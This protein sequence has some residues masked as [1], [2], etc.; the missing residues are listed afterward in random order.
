LVQEFAGTVFG[1]LENNGWKRKEKRRRKTEFFPDFSKELFRNPLG[2]NHERIARFFVERIQL[3][4]QQA[5]LFNEPERFFS[6]RFRDFPGLRWQDRY[7]VMPATSHATEF[8]T[9]DLHNN[10]LNDAP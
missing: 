1:A 3:E 5:T 10:P 2:W 8:L 6:E 9:I 4:L 7:P